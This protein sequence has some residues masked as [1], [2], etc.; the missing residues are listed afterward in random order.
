MADEL[1]IEVRVNEWATREFNGRYVPYTPQEIADASRACFDAGASIIHYHA[2]EPN[3]DRSTCVEIYAETARLIRAQQNGL[4]IMPT[5]GMTSLD[6]APE[7]IAHI[8]SM[9]S[10]PATKPELAPVDMACCSL[11]VFDDVAKYFRCI[12]DP[13][14][15]NKTS[16]WIIYAGS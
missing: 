6:T 14:I 12:G 8:Q 16:A 15:N 5:L 1:I 9:A 10:S 3:G 13:Y 2:R 4:I 7:R 11:D